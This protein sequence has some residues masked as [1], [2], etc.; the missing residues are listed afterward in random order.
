MLSF[1]YF[2]ENINTLLKSIATCAHMTNDGIGNYILVQRLH[3]FPYYVFSWPCVLCNAQ[4][5]EK[6]PLHIRMKY[7]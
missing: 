4:L 5:L 2:A 6:V 7:L 3:L 1:K